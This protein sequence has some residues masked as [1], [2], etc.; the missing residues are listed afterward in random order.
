MSHAAGSTST[1]GTRTPDSLLNLGYI[2]TIPGLL[3]TGQLFFEVV[4]LWFFVALL[5]FFFIHIFRV[6]TKTPCINCPLTEF[7]HYCVGTVLVFVA[8]VAGAC[9]SRRSVCARHCHGATV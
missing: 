4:A 6:N 2:R 5:V 7:F 8:S 9:K 3:Q 1:S